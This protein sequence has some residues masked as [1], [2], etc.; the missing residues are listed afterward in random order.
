M[1]LSESPL[2]ISKQDRTKQKQFT[3]CPTKRLL[4]LST[5]SRQSLNRI[6]QNGCYAPDRTRLLNP[7]HRQLYSRSILDGFQL[8]EKRTSHLQNSFSIELHWSLCDCSKL[9][10]FTPHNLWNCFSGYCLGVSFV[11]I[12]ARDKTWVATTELMS[13]ALCEHCVC[14]A[15]S[16]FLLGDSVTF[17]ACQ[18]TKRMSLRA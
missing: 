13:Q 4:F 12:V 14:C 5:T 18:L 17:L 9:D 3:L 7:L 16:C 15:L 8:D 6:S 11:K 1:T 10:V 2:E